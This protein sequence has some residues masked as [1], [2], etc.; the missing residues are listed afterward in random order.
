MYY[1]CCWFRRSEFEAL[2]SWLD[3]KFVIWLFFKVK[4]TKKQHLL[5]DPEYV[6]PDSVEVNYLEQNRRI[7]ENFRDISDLDV[8]RK[9]RKGAVWRCLAI[10]N[11]CILSSFIFLTAAS[12]FRVW[13]NN[14][15]CV[16]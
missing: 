14:H 16:A 10:I 3:S 15:E 2:E 13:I 7:P 9:G 4:W 8:I 11:G 1:V 12:L 6:Y 5:I